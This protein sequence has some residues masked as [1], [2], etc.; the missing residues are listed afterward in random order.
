MFKNEVL[1]KQHPTLGKQTSRAFEL[2][3]SKTF[4]HGV[5][6]YYVDGGVAEIMKQPL[7]LSGPAIKNKSTL[8]QKK[9]RDWVALN[10]AAVQ[11]G[12]TSSHDLTQFRMQHNIWQKDPAEYRH[13]KGLQLPPDFTHGIANRPSTPIDTLIRQKYQRKWLQDKK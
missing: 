3:K 13:G 2:P 7:Q 4:V 8:H 6:N 1:L 9:R 5:K 10:R 12:A 11:T